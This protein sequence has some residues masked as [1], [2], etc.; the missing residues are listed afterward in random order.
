MNSTI[1]PDTWAR[2]TQGATLVTADAHNAP[3]DDDDIE[4]VATFTDDA[5]DEEIAIALGRSLYAIWAIQT[6]IREGAITPRRRD[7]RSPITRTWDAGFDYVTTF[8]PGYL[9]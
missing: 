7:A 9:D 1:T 5:T 6:R 3:W 2:R 4:F 8:P